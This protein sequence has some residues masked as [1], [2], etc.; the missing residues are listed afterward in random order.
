L[1][2]VKTELERLR[3]LATPKAL[4]ELL[5]A[6]FGDR[7]KEKALIKDSNCWVPQEFLMASHRG[8]RKRTQVSRLD[9]SPASVAVVT[10][11]APTRKA[12][13]LKSKA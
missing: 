6:R 3:S 1:I 11:T 12:S 7:I 8:K 4:R 2:T 10:P 9:P 5:Y 13:K